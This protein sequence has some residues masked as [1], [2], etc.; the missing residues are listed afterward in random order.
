MERPVN[1]SA[2]F[3]KNPSDESQKCSSEP[4]PQT[5]TPNKIKAAWLQLNT[6]VDSE[7]EFISL[8]PRNRKKRA[9][10]ESDDESSRDDAASVTGKTEKAK[11]AEADV[12]SSQESATHQVKIYFWNKSVCSL[13][14]ENLNLFSGAKL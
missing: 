7:E 13:V 14:T 1:Y 5:S 10:I 11:E 4:G 3:L 8:P 9:M 6:S 12:Q 2:T